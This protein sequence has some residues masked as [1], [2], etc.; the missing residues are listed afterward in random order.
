MNVFQILCQQWKRKVPPNEK[1][2][3][4]RFVNP[5]DICWRKDK[6]SKGGILLGSFSNGAESTVN[7]WEPLRLK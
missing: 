3:R 5:L 2:R 1:F 6:I 4:L 7:N